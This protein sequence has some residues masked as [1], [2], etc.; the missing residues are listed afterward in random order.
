MGRI[1]KNSSY[2]KVPSIPIGK[3]TFGYEFKGLDY[4]YYS[5]II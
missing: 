1:M 5:F 4:I 3:Q 2:V